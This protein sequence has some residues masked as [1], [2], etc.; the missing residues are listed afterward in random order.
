MVIVIIEGAPKDGA[1]RKRVCVVGRGDEQA[2]KEASRLM[3]M[4]WW[5]VGTAWRGVCVCPWGPGEWDR[6]VSTW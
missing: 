1:E 5:M 3:M 4:L 6:M 2:V